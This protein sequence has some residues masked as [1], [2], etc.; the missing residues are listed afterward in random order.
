M[1]R[2]RQSVRIGLTV[3]ICALVLRLFTGGTLEPALGWLT[4]PQGS[5]V[6]LYLETGRIFRFS[7][8]ETA[9]ATV[10]TAAPAVSETTAPTTPLPAD[11][12]PCFS[13]ADTDLISL[14]NNCGY[15][16]DLEAMLLSPLSWDL[17][18]GGPAVL[19]V[20]THATESY[21]PTQAYL[22]SSDYRTLDNG[23]NMVAI[24]RQVAAVLEA[25]GIEVLHDKALHDHP[26]YTG[27]YQSSRE[28]IQAYLEAYPS[29]RMVLDIHRDAAETAYGQLKTSA[30]VDGAASSQLMMVVGTD[31]GGLDHPY[32]QKNMALAIQLTAYLEK[33]W[34]GL[35]K[36]ISFRSQRF[37][38]DLSPGA[39]LIEV[40]AAGDT[41]EEALLAAKIL[42]QAILALSRGTAT[43]HSTS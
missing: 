17:T 3:I 28:S 33:Q 19:I 39:M 36:P 12:L 30:T 6:L 38:Q 2:E 7:P 26:S 21:T 37:N 34:P 4:S 20:H 5:S 23:Y 14:S 32:W 8:R 10:P 16:P 1:N 15:T 42:G 11:T 22:S 27:A 25:G 13:P 43:A 35:T 18:Q 31:A 29:I 40:G 41:Q 24:G 9:P